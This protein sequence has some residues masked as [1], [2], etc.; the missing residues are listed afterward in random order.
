MAYV[1]PLSGHYVAL[2]LKDHV[3]IHSSLPYDLKALGSFP[4]LALPCCLSGKLPY[5]PSSSA[6][7]TQQSWSCVLWLTLNSWHVSSQWLLQAAS[8]HPKFLCSGQFTVVA[9]CRL[10]SVQTWDLLLL[11]LISSVLL[12]TSCISFLTLLI[13]VHMAQPWIHI[14]ITFRAVVMTLFVFI[15]ITPLHIILCQALLQDNF[16][17]MKERCIFGYS[18]VSPGYIFNPDFTDDQPTYIF[19]YVCLRQL[20]TSIFE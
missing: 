9:G 13:F 10:F 6:A 14:R 20:L 12:D 3:R 15:D 19:W 1:K 8:P 11:G 4:L 7:V 5:L 2:C 16:Q 18:D 17:I